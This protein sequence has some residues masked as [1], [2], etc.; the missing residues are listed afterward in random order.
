MNRITADQLEAWI[1][2]ERLHRYRVH[3][4]DTVELY[5][6][7]ARRS[8]HM[9]EL[10]LHIEVLIRNVIHRELS[11]TDRATQIPWYLDTQ[12]YGFNRQMIRNLDKAVS[13]AGGPRAPGG[14]VVAELMFGT[15]RFLLST[16]YQATVWPVAARGFTGR[17]RSQRDRS[18]LHAAMDYLNGVRNRCSHSEPVYHLDDA[19]FI[20]NASTA[21]GY[22]D[23]AAAS[24]LETLWAQRLTENPFPTA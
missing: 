12:H 17:V 24:W 6:Y 9:S 15:W 8:T 22:V 3:S 14:K 2:P 23:T 1:S 10:I 4:A 7:N 5:M 18:E 11:S 21:A 16:Q 19:E 13:T 20:G